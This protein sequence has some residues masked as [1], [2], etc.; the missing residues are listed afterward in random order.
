MSKKQNQK[1]KV[2][3]KVSAGQAVF[4]AELA[5]LEH[6][7][8]LYRSMASTSEDPDSWM[9]VANSIIDWVNRTYIPEGDSYDDEEEW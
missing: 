6:I 9:V 2:T 5:V 8:D 4:V 7:A 1:K 3:V